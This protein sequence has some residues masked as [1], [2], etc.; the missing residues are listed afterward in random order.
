MIRKQL[1]GFESPRAA[2]APDRPQPDEVEKSNSRA[3]NKRV[4]RAK[5][6][7]NRFIWSC[8]GGWQH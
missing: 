6:N 3:A 5:K 8:I 7:P 4:A 1:F 2:R